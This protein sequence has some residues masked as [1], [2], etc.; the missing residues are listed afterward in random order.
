MHEIK[1]HLNKYNI[2][3]WSQE[4]LDEHKLELKELLAHQSNNP[5]YFGRDG[6]LS[7]TYFIND[8]ET[9]KIVIHN[10]KSGENLIGTIISLSDLSNK[11][12]SH[13]NYFQDKKI[14][15]AK[16]ENIK[17]V[18]NNF[19]IPLYAEDL[20]PESQQNIYK[21]FGK[22]TYE[23]RFKTGVSSNNLFYYYGDIHNA[24][25]SCIS[26]GVADCLAFDQFFT[27]NFPDKS[28]L[29]VSAMSNSN[30]IHTIKIIKQKN[31]LI[32][33]IFYLIDRD[34]KITHG[35]NDKAIIS[36]G[37]GEMKFAEAQSLDLGNTILFP[38]IS[39]NNDKK[40]KEDNVYKYKIKDFSDIYADG[41]ELEY[42]KNS[43]SSFFNKRMSLD[44]S[45][46]LRLNSVNEK[47]KCI[48]PVP[49]IIQIVKEKVKLFKVRS[50]DDNLYLL[51]PMTS[52]FELIPEFHTEEVSKT[53]PYYFIPNFVENCFKNSP[54]QFGIIDNGKLIHSIFHKIKH[55]DDY[56]LDLDTG[57]NLKNGSIDIKNYCYKKEYLK[58]TK[59]LKWNYF[60]DNE[61]SIKFNNSKVKSF[62]QG[63]MPDPDDYR[64]LEESVGNS[65]ADGKREQISFYCGNG[66]NGKSLFLIMLATAFGDFCGRIPF[67]KIMNNP[68]ARTN[69]VNK[70]LI[71][72]TEFSGKLTDPEFYKTLVSK[73]EI[74]VK[75]LYKDVIFPK[76]LPV[77]IVATNENLTIPSGGGN[78][79]EAILRRTA[80]LC[81][82][83]K[84]EQNVA[85][86]ES[87]LE[88]HEVEIFFNWA[89]RCVM[90]MKGKNGITLSKN[91]QKYKNEISKNINAVSSFVSEYEIESGTHE[92]QS[93][94]FYELFKKFCEDNGYGVAN[95]RNFKE[96][97]LDRKITS[98]KSMHY[99]VY[100][101][102]KSIKDL[103]NGVFTG[104]N[105][106]VINSDNSNHILK[107]NE[108]LS[109]IQES[110][111]Q[112][113]P[114]GW[115]NGATP[116][117]I[118]PVEKID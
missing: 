24:E 97:L 99:N 48:S 60:D 75:T 65:L 28:L 84:F 110:V 62:L 69:M 51:N 23:K 113:K 80:P 27:D 38:I 10:F 76:N 56:L 19:E 17:L 92:V 13:C 15:I 31:P 35:D 114:P 95:I 72:S 89:V 117:N 115:K 100:C 93:S 87:L 8:D 43:I 30:L 25:Y 118:N 71:V 88:D 3:N 90:K 32:K 52:T 9:E 105:V 18:K 6:K 22:D 49:E 101:I 63:I 81:F 54:P 116:F 12:N 36:A 98:K 20:I 107:I 11:S 2:E 29:A 102:N 40:L 106:S 5:I 58:A 112:W 96:R 108:P 104:E 42:W 83:Q 79:T 16:Y 50:C 61:Y 1:E 34:T 53:H 86:G 57:F 70:I 4:E 74:E 109:P 67:D 33:V 111:M 14:K 55:D 45:D 59:Y 44:K 46:I 94:E 91:S 41:A 103:E 37:L 21:D 64:Q 77:P 73:E 66:Q 85:F 26:E 68:N 47:G 82:S 39:S 78:N 7:I